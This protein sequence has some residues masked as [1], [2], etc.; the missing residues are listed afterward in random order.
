MDGEAT[1]AAAMQ[2]R[3][4]AE[5]TMLPRIRGVIDALK[6]MMGPHNAALGT[7]GVEA[8]KAPA[9]LTSV[10]LAERAA[11]AKATRVARG[12]LGSKQKSQIKGTVTAPAAPPVTPVTPPKAGG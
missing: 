7:Y 12:T 4:S 3:T 1:L 6:G 2:A 9:P 8:D 10:Q 5:A 11:K